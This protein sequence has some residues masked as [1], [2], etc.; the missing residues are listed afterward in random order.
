[1]RNLAQRSADAKEIKQLITHSVE[2]VE[3]G[4]AQAD[5]AGSTMT[6][7]SCSPSAA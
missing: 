4:T 2:Q 5:R 7:R 6:G 3:R 1:M